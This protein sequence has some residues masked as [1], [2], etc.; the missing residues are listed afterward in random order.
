M[1]LHLKQDV[2]INMRIQDT[3]LK[4]SSPCLIVD[5][6]KGGVKIN[7]VPLIS[8]QKCGLPPFCVVKPYSIKSPR[9]IS[10]QVQPVHFQS[11][12]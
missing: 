10:I 7:I 11:Q 6:E 3:T 12:Q 2:P 9:N 8:F 5:V 1:G 4:S